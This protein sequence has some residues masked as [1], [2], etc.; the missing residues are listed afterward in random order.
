MDIYELINKYI[1]AGYSENDAIPKVAQDI[2]LL[3]IGNS[4]YSKNITVK[5]NIEMLKNLA[6]SRLSSLFLKKIP[7]FLFLY[8][9]NPPELDERIP[10]RETC[11]FLSYFV[12]K[13][14]IIANTV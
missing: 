5:I 1:L 14:R 6:K 11:I 10:I 3:K 8:T 12:E 4:K 9:Y 2:V 13:C 7:S